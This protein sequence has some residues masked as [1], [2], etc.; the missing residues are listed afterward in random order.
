MK[1]KLIEGMIIKC[2]KFINGI[3]QSNGVT[4]V[5]SHHETAYILDGEENR[6]DDITRQNKE[7][8]V[9]GAK[10]RSPQY[11]IGNRTTSYWNEFKAKELYDD[12]TYYDKGEEILFSTARCYR[13]SINEEEIEVIG[14]MKKV[15]V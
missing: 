10:E 15:F 12:G 1:T 5:G 8:V 7:Y 3:R 13:S 6:R 14:Q 4:F 9:T 11:S 2:H